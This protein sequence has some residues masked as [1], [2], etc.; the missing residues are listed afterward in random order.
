MS[1]SI[2]SF[3]FREYEEGR[4][5]CLSLT[6][7]KEYK[8]SP[9]MAFVSCVDIHKSMHLFDRFVHHDH[10][11]RLNAHASLPEQIHYENFF[12]F[13]FHIISKRCSNSQHSYDYI[14]YFT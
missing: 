14:S 4:T 8:I 13:S 6:S 10:A 2:F 11:I 9:S 5:N 1:G 12:V 3:V 7:S